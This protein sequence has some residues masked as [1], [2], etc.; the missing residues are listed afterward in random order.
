MASVKAAFN[1][2]SSIAAMAMEASHNISPLQ[3]AVREM[4][5]TLEPVREQIRLNTS[6]AESFR[7]KMIINQSFFERVTPR[8][9]MP[10]A[11]IPQFESAIQAMD[12]SIIKEVSESFTLFNKSVL[13]EIMTRQLYVNVAT[14]EVSDDLSDDKVI[15]WEWISNKIFTHSQAFGYYF[16]VT[17]HFTL[18]AHGIITD[19]SYIA[20]LATLSGYIYQEQESKRNKDRD[21]E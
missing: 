17:M 19:P 20:L 11:V 4:D 12:I 2:S 21:T 3:Q 13:N 16:I 7:E 14:A 8:F 18:T 9:E 10:S 1:Y 5:S 6:F 15:F